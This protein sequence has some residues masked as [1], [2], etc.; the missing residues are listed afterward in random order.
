ML[1]DLAGKVVDQ[2]YGLLDVALA[3]YNHLMEEDL[4]RMINELHRNHVYKTG[5]LIDRSYGPNVDRGQTLIETK[6]FS[7]FLSFA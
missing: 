5:L 2:G 4:P 7:I 3:S 1:R 6:S